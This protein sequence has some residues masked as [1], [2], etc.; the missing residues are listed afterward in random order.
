MPQSEPNTSFSMPI[1]CPI[2]RNSTACRSI[3]SPPLMS[4]ATFA[5]QRAT[6]LAYS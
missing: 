5:R 6:E 3:V 4:K 1:S 2:S